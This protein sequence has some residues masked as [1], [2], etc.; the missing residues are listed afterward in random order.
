MDAQVLSKQAN[1]NRILIP[2]FLPP[3]MASLQIPPASR[4]SV[5]IRSKFR[6]L[7]QSIEHFVSN[8]FHQERSDCSVLHYSIVLHQGCKN[9]L[10]RGRS[11]CSVQHIILQREY[12]VAHR[13]LH[14]QVYGNNKQPYLF[15]FI[16][17]LWVVFQH[18]TIQCSRFLYWA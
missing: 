13:F 10:H 6:F 4:I 2:K 7:F 18:S 1:L 17:S 14:Q 12:K 16:L 5:Q 3:F 11:D 9:I 8:I 15:P